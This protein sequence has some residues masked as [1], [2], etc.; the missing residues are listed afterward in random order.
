M[1]NII[2]GIA[3][4]LHKLEKERNSWEE[5]RYRWTNLYLK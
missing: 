1:F 2:L 3:V 4:I 5:S